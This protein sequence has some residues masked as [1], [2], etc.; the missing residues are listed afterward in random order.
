MTTENVLAEQARDAL[1][2][3]MRERG[4]TQVQL[5]DVLGITQVAVSTRVTGRTPLSLADIHRLARFWDVDPR[6][7]LTS[8]SEFA[9][10]TLVLL[11]GDFAWAA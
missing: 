11:S 4:T 2:R 3:L 6:E 7:F 5:A 8:G 1:R 10:T 9:C